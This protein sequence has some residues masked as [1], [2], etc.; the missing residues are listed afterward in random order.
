MTDLNR[1]VGKKFHRLL[2]TNLTW[3]YDR[4]YS[5]CQCDCGSKKEIKPSHLL[6]GKTKSCGRYSVE[7]TSKINKGKISPQLK[8]DN[9]SA[10]YRVF[11]SYKKHAKNRNL[12]F[13]LDLQTFLELSS[14]P[15]HYCGASPTN[16]MNG[17]QSRSRYVYNGID[18]VNNLIG[19][20]SYNCVPCCKIYNMGK[21]AKDRDCFLTWIKSVYIHSVLVK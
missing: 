16:S 18:R 21:G 9:Y 19:Y 15:C 7:I 3:K 20:Q 12:S 10:K 17:K 5:Q 8:P 11:Q 14:K 4:T 1:H 2:I 6:S 13:G